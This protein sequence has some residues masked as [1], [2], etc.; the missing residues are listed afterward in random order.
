MNNLK[1][2]EMKVYF[3]SLPPNDKFLFY[4]SA[5]HNFNNGIDPPE[6]Y[7]Q[8]ED[9][10]LTSWYELAVKPITPTGGR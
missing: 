1:I 3:D 10:I 8:R 4:H 6:R 7:S 9:E 5:M 2:Q